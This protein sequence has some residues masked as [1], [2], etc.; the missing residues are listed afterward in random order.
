[1]AYIDPPALRNRLPAGAPGLDDPELQGLIDNWKDL[2]PVED[3]TSRMAVS[4]G[5]QADARQIVLE[6]DGYQTDDMTRVLSEQAD[7]LRRSYE[8][9]HPDDP[10]PAAAA[11][12]YVE[13]WVW[14]A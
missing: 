14:D 11:P 5:A 7:R 9:A 12:S 8:A 10:G 1:M 3:A 6:R 13:Q 2:F 4:K